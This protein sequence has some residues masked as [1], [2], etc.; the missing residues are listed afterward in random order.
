MAKTNTKTTA[1]PIRTHEGGPAKRINALS[2][3]KRTVLCCLLWEKSFYEEGVDIVTR[4]ANLIPQCDP[5]DVAQLAVTARNDYHLRHVPLLIVRL[6]AGLDSHKHL[7]ASTLEAVIQRPDEL[8][9]FVS[10]YW[11]TSKKK[12]LSPLSSQIKKGLAKAFTKFDAYQ[13]AKWNKD[14]DVKLR[15]VLFLL[16]SSKTIKQSPRENLEAIGK[17]NSSYP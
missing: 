16:N 8:S 6:M 14:A 3:L 2:Q 1:T 15:D 5:N 12:N 17:W 4:I 10:L 9:E 13:L 11:E 7:V